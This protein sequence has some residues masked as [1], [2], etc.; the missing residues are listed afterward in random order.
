MKTSLTLFTLAALVALAPSS[1]QAQN[2]LSN[3]NL[4]LTQATEI[5]PAFFLPKPTNWQNFGTR[6]ISGPYEDEMASEPWAGPAPTPVTIDGLANPPH[7]AGCGGGDCGVFFK[8]FSGSVTNGPATG[9]LTQDVPATPGV[10]YI[11]T[12]WAG[13]EPNVLMTGAEIALEFLDA[14]DNVIGGSVVNLL[15]TLIVDNGQPFDYK[16]YT[17]TATAPA[18]TVEARARASM[19]GGLSNPAGGGQ[20][21]VVDDFVL[22]VIPEPSTLALG[23]AGLLSLVGLARRRR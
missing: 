3:G 1:A 16:Q 17:A 20:A 11:L 13:A 18:G 10:R 9:H 15:P 8:P 2:L 6:T 5:V 14:G 23:L 21:Y 4:D 12:G 19:I 7:P 22:R